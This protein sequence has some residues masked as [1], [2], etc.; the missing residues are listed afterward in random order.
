MAQSALSLLASVL[1]C[2]PYIT[3]VSVD[4]I[5]KRLQKVIVCINSGECGVNFE[6]NVESGS[7]SHVD[8]NNR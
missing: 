2:V 5:P 4:V 7:L 1:V 3:D 8:Q 6:T